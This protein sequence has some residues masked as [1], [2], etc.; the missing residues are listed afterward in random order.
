MTTA[1]V[2]CAAVAAA[3]MVFAGGRAQA[4]EFTFAVEP[5]VPPDRA[6]QKDKLGIGLGVVHPGISYVRQHFTGHVG[7]DGVAELLDQL[8]ARLV[9]VLVLRRQSRIQRQHFS[10]AILAP[11]QRLVDVANLTLTGQEHQYIAAWIQ[12]SDF[13]DGGHD[14]GGAGIRPQPRHER[15]VDLQELA[16]EAAQR[17]Q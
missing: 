9:G 3:L 12:A 2:L 8:A 1:K 17:R 7:I 16:G 10:L 13:V 5:S 6:A 15:P 11:F 14:G 4:A